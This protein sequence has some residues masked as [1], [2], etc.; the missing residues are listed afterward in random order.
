MAL[1][2]CTLFASCGS[3]DDDPSSI[4]TETRVTFEAGVLER[5]LPVRARATGGSAVRVVVSTSGPVRL[6]ADDGDGDERG[7]DTNESDDLDVS[8]NVANCDFTL[9]VTR[10]DS[11]DTQTVRLALEASARGGCDGDP[12]DTVE[13][14][15][16]G[17]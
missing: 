17:E 3:C 16:K 14:E 6:S 7:F 1:V 9:V 11:G 5:R 15:V 8:C 13:L 12:P 2:L 4:A 10:D